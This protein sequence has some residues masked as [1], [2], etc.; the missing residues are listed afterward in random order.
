VEKGDLCQKNEPVRNMDKPQI[1]L[2]NDDGIRS[3]GLWAAAEAL[4]ALGF[5]TVVAP[6]EQQSGSGR[7]MPVTSDGVI[8]E[9]SMKVGGKDWRVYAVGGTP[10]Q[11]VLHAVLELMPQRPDL[12]VSGINFGENVGAGI[13]ISGTIGAA[14]EGAALGI[15]SMAFSLETDIKYHFSHSTEVNFAAAAHFTQFFARKLLKGERA[16]DVDVLKVDVPS[17]ATPETPWRIT[18]QSRVR[19]FIPVKP[20]RERLDEPT[21]IGYRSL[22]EYDALE[23]GTDAHTLY[24]ERLVAVT[25]LS[26]DLTSRI[27][28]DDYETYLRG[29][30][31]V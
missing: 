9:E 23:P 22:A 20:D 10:A 25:P 4:S 19:F 13:T 1:L 30:N 12:I 15:P 29:I 7:S 17:D 5:V 8:R 14:L 26:L 3:P 6:R 16:K 31:S 27:A 21:S 28:L 18:R 24:V 2:T 11:A